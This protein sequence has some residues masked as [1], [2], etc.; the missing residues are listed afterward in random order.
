MK[1]AAA[2]LIGPVILGLGAAEVLIPFIALEGGI[3]W[4]WILHLVG[5]VY[6][7]LL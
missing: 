1:V 4:L 3:R 5:G 6:S 7:V 2:L